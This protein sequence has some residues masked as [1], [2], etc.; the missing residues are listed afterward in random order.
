MIYFHIHAYINRDLTIM[1]YLAVP[2]VNLFDLETQSNI[3]DNFIVYMVQQLFNKISGIFITINYLILDFHLSG[4]AIF[5]IE[6]LLDQSDKKLLSHLQK[7]FGNEKEG[8]SS[9][10]NSVI[11]YFFVGIAF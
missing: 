3:S 2:F 10:F 11:G 8:L 1:K 5:Q 7:Q 4:Q 9:L 6:S